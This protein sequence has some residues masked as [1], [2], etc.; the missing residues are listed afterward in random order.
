MFSG[1]SS[2]GLI[3]PRN[4]MPVFEIDHFLFDGNTTGLV[5]IGPLL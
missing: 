5:Y 2:I 4:H 3:E 1:S